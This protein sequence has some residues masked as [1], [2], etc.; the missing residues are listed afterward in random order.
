MR[1]ATNISGLRKVE[2]KKA[3]YLKMFNNVVEARKH[4]S[5]LVGVANFDQ[6]DLTR[7][8]RDMAEELRAL[9]APRRKPI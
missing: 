6:A 2:K 9:Q 1:N 7:E 3:F 8:L 4:L 5:E